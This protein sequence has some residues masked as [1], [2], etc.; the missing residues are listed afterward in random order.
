[1][2]VALDF[3]DVGLAECVR[4]V[5]NHG[6]DVDKQFTD[7]WSLEQADEAYREFDKQSGGK[8]VILF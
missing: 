2:A 6:L 3:S 1:V 7:H 4:F 5:A 8:S